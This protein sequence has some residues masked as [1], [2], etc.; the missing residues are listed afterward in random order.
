MSTPI[1]LVEVL[2]RRAS[3]QPNVMGYTFLADGE[4]AVDA[5]PWADLADRAARIAGRL[6]RS[7]RPG[8]PLLLLVPPGLDF[9]AAFMGCLFAARIAVPLP[10]PAR[11]RDLRRMEAIIADADIT[12]VLSNA[13][14]REAVARLPSPPPDLRWLCLDEDGSEAPWRHPDVRGDTVA[15]IQYTS[16]STRSPRGVVV[17]H[18]NLLH[19]AAFMAASFGYHADTVSVSWLPPH[20]DMG[21]IEGILQPLCAGFSCYLMSPAAFLQ[22]PMRWLEAIS[23]FG[24]THAGAPNFAYDLCVARSTPEA[25]NALDLGRWRVAYDGAEPVRE[26]TLRRF[27]EAFALAGFRGAA[28]HPCYGLAEATLKVSGGHRPSGPLVLSVS[29]E[30]LGRRCVVHPSGD[31]DA[32]VLVGCGAVDPALTARIVHPETMAPCAPDEVGE[33]WL[34]GP[35]IASGYH[36]HA[37]DTARTFGVHLPDGAGPFLRTGDLG[38]FHGGELFLSGRLKDVLI[39]RGRN[40]YPDDIELAAERA[41][42]RVRP[43]CSAAFAS[44]G[45]GGERAALV[46]EVDAGCTEAELAEMLG[47]IRAAVATECELQLAAVTLIRPRTIPKTSSG[48]IQRQLCRSRFLARELEAVASF[49]EPARGEAVEDRRATSPLE[50]IAD[51]LAAR[52]GLAAMDPDAPLVSQGLDSLLAAELTALLER[53]FGRSLPPASLLDRLTPAQVVERLSEAPP[54]L[55]SAGDADEGGADEAPLCAG[56][57]ALWFLHLLA[58]DAPTYNL[59][60]AAELDSVVDV[61]ALR[62]AFARVVDRHP[63]LR[64]SFHGRG[65]EPVQRVH[66]RAALAFE[67]IDASSWSEQAIA[68]R[69][70]HE[71]HRPFSLAES[72]LRLVLLRRAA[73]GHAMVLATHHIVADLASFAV[74]LRDLGELYAGRA[75]PPLRARHADLARREA[76]LLASEAGERQWHF[77]RDRLAG[78]PALD[79]PLDRLRPAVSTHPGA[80]R[81]M[82]LDPPVVA[83][84]RALARRRGTT[85]A[86][87][88]LAAFFALLR[89][90]TAQ[91]DICVGMPTHGRDRSELAD[92]VGYFVNP[93]V[94]R[95]DLGDDPPFAGLLDRTHAAV[96]DALA[97]RDYPFARLVERLVP[98]RDPAR[99]PLFQVAFTF[100]RVPGE[101]PGIAAA[102]L[103]DE[104]VRLALSGL[105]LALRPLPQRASPFELGLFIAERDGGLSA[106][107]QYA[108]DLFD[109]TTIDML[110]G[111]YRAVLEAAVERP[112]VRV[113]DLAL[114]EARPAP[115]REPA[116]PGP[117]VH[118]LFEAQAARAPDAE[119]IVGVRERWS[120]G[121]LDRRANGIAHRLRASGVG[122]E[123][124]VAV[125]LERGPLL[126]AALLAVLKAGGAFVP[127]DPATPEARVARLVADVGARAVLTQRELRPRLPA[128]PESILA[129]ATAD[130][131]APPDVD[132]P[133]AALA[134]VLYTS[135]S[136]GTPKGVAIEHRSATAFLTWAIEAYGP[137]RLGGV[138][139]SSSV[140]FDLSIFEIFAPLACGKKVILADNVLVCAELPAAAELTLVNTVPSAMTQLLR[141]AALPP[142]V[143]TVNLAGE[144][145]SPALVASLL[146]RPHVAEVF[147]LYGPTEHTT[148]ATRALRSVGAPATI[149]APIHDTRAHVLDRNLAPVPDGMPGELYLAGSGQARGYVGH[150]ARTAE[151]FVPDPFSAAPG[152]R[153]YRTGDRVRRLADGALQFLGRV[154]AEVKIRGHRVQPAEVERVI[155]D[156]PG[157]A[158]AAVNTRRAPTGDVEIVAYVA[159]LIGAALDSD[160]LRALARRQ[161]PAYML[162]ARWVVLDSLPL[163]A[164]GKLDR[165]ALPPPREPARPEGRPFIAPRTATEEQIA[166]IWRVVLGVASV[167]VADDFFDLGGHSLLAA[168]VVARLRDAFGVEL[169][170]SAM[171][172]NPTV[173]VLGALV[174]ASLAAPGRLAP[175]PPIGRADSEL[176]AAI[177]RLPDEEMEQ[178]LIEL[179]KAEQV[180]S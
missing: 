49:R 36:G 13:A 30:A 79:L 54:P 10:P 90:Y 148:Y 87:L 76:G 83:G 92:V 143:R 176:E 147:D 156:L 105:D 77:W 67:V 56:Q 50:A 18:D 12:E 172:A 53:C 28:F 127:I 2:E 175:A 145:L 144:A 180:S 128:A 126:V 170:M 111:A 153:L 116:A 52:I 166:Q 65:A 32:K 37:E 133:P 108:S 9:I 43:G 94:I 165:A 121:T 93:V 129:E 39:L 162:P 160:A 1:S 114:G 27:A 62:A 17:R 98:A 157:V 135:G 38:F 68:E 89:R 125:Y 146:A 107:F 82:W 81:L 158:R 155:V 118:R 120:Y 163:T 60:L 57:R 138:L 5:M 91:D 134:Y 109:H 48:K 35:S 178:M 20:H 6:R 132:V 136:T 104:G 3:L 58:P 100:Q 33:L 19:N 16:G 14:V 22:R 101:V 59:A 142:S 131:D 110:L 177:Q 73:G 85:L 86:T 122:P 152:G 113:G 44:D 61:A 96:V 123:V 63:C 168:Q 41:D 66:A 140:G 119:A 75:M 115:A 150:P 169:P 11:E 149:G 137:D 7:G 174:E 112:E 103:G 171:L 124:L 26:D 88:L 106:C 179:L 80:A 167:A 130:A 71:A 164:H 69:L 15:F 151:R 102:A 95:L 72:P 161:L 64:A 47:S 154:D 46:C 97:H 139:A 42:A 34:A 51:F 40:V 74:M 45:D 70:D 78:A 55:V 21:L 173:E 99:A 141:L 159:P 29:R 31:E 4:R 23:R 117:P 8:E 84:L 24:A 25:R